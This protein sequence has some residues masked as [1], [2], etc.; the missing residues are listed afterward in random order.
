M[1]TTKTTES[2]ITKARYAVC[3]QNTKNKTKTNRR[4]SPLYN[5]KEQLY[6]NIHTHMHKCIKKKKRNALLKAPQYRNCSPKNQIVA[7]IMSECIHIHVTERQRA[8]IFL[9]FL[10]GFVCVYG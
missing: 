8:I 3:K 10:N 9:L 2:N 7:R 1:K 5:N 6:T 4:K